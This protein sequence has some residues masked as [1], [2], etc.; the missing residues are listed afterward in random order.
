MKK[1]LYILFIA[2][3]IQI[4][5]CK[6]GQEDA[7]PNQDLTSIPYNPLTYQITYPS[8][9]PQPSIPS[10]NPITNDGILLGRHL[11]LTLFFLLTVVCPVLPCHHPEKFYR[12]SGYK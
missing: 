12:W 11:F 10:D 9:F 4:L 1:I 7:E 3:I 5:S 8:A 6:D 2:N